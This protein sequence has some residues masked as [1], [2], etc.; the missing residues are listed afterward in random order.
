MKLLL[1]LLLA[2]GDLSSVAHPPGAKG[3]DPM[4]PILAKLRDTA[5]KSVVAIEVEREADPDGITGSGAVAQHRDYYNRPK[6]PTSG[7]LY[8]ADGF[9]LTSRFNVSGTLRKNW[10]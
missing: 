6:G 8:E 2:A 10:I 9:I 7:V 4:A 5:A 1:A 3:D